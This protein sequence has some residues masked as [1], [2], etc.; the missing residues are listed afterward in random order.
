M[1]P[2]H[3]LL[4]IFAALCLLGFGLMLLWERRQ[5]RQRGLGGPWLVVRLASIPLALLTAALVILP[6]RST[7]G[8]EGLGVFY[9]MLLVVA[10]PLWVGAHWLVGK[11]VRP[12]LS[13]NDALWIAASPILFVMAVS[14]LAPM[15]QRIAWTALRAMGMD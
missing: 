5:F 13:F 6:A 2:F 11:I 4:T 14:V 15:L 7:S 12:A 1:H 9:V 10:P 8:M 3:V